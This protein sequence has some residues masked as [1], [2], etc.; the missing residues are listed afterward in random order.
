MNIPWRFFVALFAGFVL[1]IAAF[2][3]MLYVILGVPTRSSQ[4]IYDITQKKE[5]IAEHDNGRRLFIVAGSSSLFSLNAKLIQDQTGIPTVNDG[6]HAA[7]F[8][9]YR[10]YQLKRLVRPGDII[11]FAWEYEYYVNSAKHDPEITDD[12]VLARDPSYFRQSPLW[13]KVSMA[14]RV[15]FDRIKLGWK[16]RHTPEKIDPPVFPYHPYTPITPGIDCLDENGDEVFNQASW[17][18][19]PAETLKDASTNTLDAGIVEKD[20]TGL[21]ELAQFIRWAQARHIGLLATFPAVI[22]NPIYETQK[23]RESSRVLIQFYRDHQVDVLGTP[24][25]ELRISLHLVFRYLLSPHSLK[26]PCREPISFCPCSR[27]NWKPL[28]D[29]GP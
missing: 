27:P 2:I 12:Y 18:K 22:K 8:I 10:L 29:H 26:P 6:I 20:N 21:E 9:E 5:Q 3:G 1:S 25:K 14:T 23:A 13:Y 4:W 24:R 16:I 11:L 15:N 19:L 17:R 7:I 28:T